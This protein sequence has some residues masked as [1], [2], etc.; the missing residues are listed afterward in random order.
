MFCFF[1]EVDLAAGSWSCNDA[2]S[3]TGLDI[4]TEETGFTTMLVEKSSLVPSQSPNL[5]CLTLFLFLFEEDF[6][7][8]WTSGGKDVFI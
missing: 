4:M 3:D 6:K 1:E 8:T 5:V 7:G 2:S